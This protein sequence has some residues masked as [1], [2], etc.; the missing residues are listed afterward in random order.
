MKCDVIDRSE[1]TSQLHVF[2]LG[3]L[4]QIEIVEGDVTAIQ[5]SNFLLSWG[6]KCL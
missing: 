1:V 6:Q 5:Y 3:H 4:L 2:V